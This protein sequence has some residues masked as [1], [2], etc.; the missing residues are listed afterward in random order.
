MKGHLPIVCLQARSQDFA[1]GGF[2]RLPSPSLASP[3]PFP[4]WRAKKFFLVL[5]MLVGKFL[6]ILDAIISTVLP[7]VL[8]MV[9]LK[10][11]I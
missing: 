4:L 6:C 9:N 8:C 2:E 10:F 7:Q 11:L 5:Q 1:L 3:L